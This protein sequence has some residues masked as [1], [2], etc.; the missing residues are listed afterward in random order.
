VKHKPLG[1]V[2]VTVTIQVVG[3]EDLAEVAAMAAGT[4]GEVVVTADKA[5]EVGAADEARAMI[6]P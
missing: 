1:G 4:S 3:P 2:E 6:T 5:A